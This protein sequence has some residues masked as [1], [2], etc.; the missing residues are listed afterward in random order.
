MV[1][2]RTA[3]PLQA[4][5]TFP[6]GLA[7]LGTSVNHRLVCYRTADEINRIY[8]FIREILFGRIAMDETTHILN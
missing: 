2:E 5:V 7:K 4:A 1:H 3:S 8:E 6:I